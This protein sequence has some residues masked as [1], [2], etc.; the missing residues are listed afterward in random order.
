MSLKK[1]NDLVV[2]DYYSRYIEILNLPSTASSQ[3][4]ARYGVPEIL[5]SD[6]AA[7]LVSAGMRKFSEDY[8]F[9]HVTSN[10]HFPQSNGHAER[11]VQIAKGILK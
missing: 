1:Q 10:P 4:V 7:N 2:P 11:A 9:V 3:V 8:D 6:D 5:L